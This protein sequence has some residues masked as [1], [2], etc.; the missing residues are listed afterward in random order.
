LQV[1]LVAHNSIDSTACVTICAGVLENECL[2]KIVMDGNPI[3]EE[4]AKALMVLLTNRSDYS[5]H[6]HISLNSNR[7]FC[8]LKVTADNG[9]FSY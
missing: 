3:G 5:L 9:W 2:S 6:N 1:L 8:A 4:G 7:F